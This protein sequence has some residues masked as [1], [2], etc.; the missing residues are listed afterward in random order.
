MA[1]T[2][3]VAQQL[4]ADNVA[5]SPAEFLSACTMCELQRGTVAIGA[6]YVRA[7]RDELRAAGL[8]DEAMSDLAWAIAI[9]LERESWVG[10]FAE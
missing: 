1:I 6:D 10:Q 3:E 8:D 5:Q 9:V 7:Y 2:F 4:F